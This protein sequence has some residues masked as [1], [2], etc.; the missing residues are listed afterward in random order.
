MEKHWVLT[1]KDKQAL[2]V[3]ER[4]LLRKIFGT[5]K[6]L[7]EYWIRYNTELYEFYADIDVIQHINVQILRWTGHVVRIDGGALAKE[8]FK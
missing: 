4:K 8:V 5:I 1:H 3:Y 2:G 7:G 6:I